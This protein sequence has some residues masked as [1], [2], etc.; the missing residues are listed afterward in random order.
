MKIIRRAHPERPYPIVTLCGSTRFQKEFRRLE[1]E[2]TYHGYVVLSVHSY[3]HSDEEDEGREVNLKSMLDDM[4][5]Y[6]IEQADM[7]VVINKD[8]YI[9][10]STAREIQYAQ[11]LGKMLLY[12]DNRV[13][14]RTVIEKK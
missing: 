11:Q 6:K 2:F 5:L 12:V 8:G 9:G 4:H 7:V 10:E 3:A 14:Q 1:K 13:L